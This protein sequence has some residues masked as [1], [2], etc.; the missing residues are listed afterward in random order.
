MAYLTYTFNFVIVFHNSLE[1][2]LLNKMTSINTLLSLPKQI[3][4]FCTKSAIQFGKL[5]KIFILI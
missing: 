1:N 5:L 2:H 4:L 3:F